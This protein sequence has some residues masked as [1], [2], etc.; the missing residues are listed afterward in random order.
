MLTWP[1][2]AGLRSFYRLSCCTNLKL[3]TGPFVLWEVLFSAN[4]SCGA[5]FFSYF[6]RVNH[7][8]QGYL[9]RNIYFHINP[10]DLKV[11]YTH[12]NRGVYC[13]TNPQGY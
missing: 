6:I 2:S 1:F 3:E 11:T 4:T 12:E 13:S 10:H 8:N 9:R 7:K 5:F